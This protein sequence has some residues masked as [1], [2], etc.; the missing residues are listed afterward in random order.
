MTDR[1]SLQ[2][3]VIVLTGGLGRLGR[4]YTAG[5]LDAGASL[6]VL[7]RA[8]VVTECGFPPTEKIAYVACDVTD[9]AS[10]VNALTEVRNRLGEPTGLINNAGLDSP[11]GSPAE[12]NGPF[13]TYP[14][15]SLH[16]VIEVNS[17]GVV[18]ACQV[19][20][21]AMAAGG[22]GSI[23]NIGSI[24]GMVSP[25]QRLYQHRRASG[26]NFFK[27]VAYAVSKSSIYNLTRYLATYWGE[28]NVRVNTLTLGG[29]FDNQDGEF[30]AAYESRVPLG[31][32]ASADD[33]VGPLVY[34]LGDASRYMTGSNLVVDGGWT[35]W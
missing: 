2:E 27:P 20:G 15:E 31:R 19:F 12:E 28:R 11:P 8:E 5:L 35:A 10:L 23:V 33:Y 3:R 29:V 30:V 1:F 17:I 18:V 26:E 13:E 24:Y 25:D 6:A 22:G 14:V 9:R 34:L 32:M 4:V 21:G 7:D 16:Q